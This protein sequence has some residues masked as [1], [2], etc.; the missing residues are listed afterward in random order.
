MNP[1][2]LYIYCVIRI[3][4]FWKNLIQFLYNLNHNSHMYER[5]KDM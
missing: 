1:T 5:K 2:H 4:V 3:Y